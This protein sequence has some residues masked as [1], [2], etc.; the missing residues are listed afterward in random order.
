MKKSTPANTHKVF[1]SVSIQLTAALLT[2]I[3]EATFIGFESDSLERDRKIILIAYPESAEPGFKRVL[4]EFESKTLCVNL[5]Y[6]NRNL[7]F[8]RDRIFSR[9][10]GR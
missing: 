4:D 3:S 10:V 9:K 7:N 5:F 2:D 6:Y 8:L 1:K